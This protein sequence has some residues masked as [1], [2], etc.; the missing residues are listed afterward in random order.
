MPTYCRLLTVNNKNHDR[1]IREKELLV[2]PRVARLD[3]QPAF[4]YHRSRF[5]LLTIINYQS[6][7]HMFSHYKIVRLTAPIFDASEAELRA[8]AARGLAVAVVDAEH[9]DELIP[10]VADADIVALIGTKLP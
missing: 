5:R 9:S 8:F 6:T 3:K 4:K 10:L 1:T 2:K 7:I